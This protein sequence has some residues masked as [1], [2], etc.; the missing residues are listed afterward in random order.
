MCPHINEMQTNLSSKR[1]VLDEAL[2]AIQAKL[3]QDYKQKCKIHPD[4][5]KNR[6]PGGNETK[7]KTRK[8]V[9]RLAR[10]FVGGLVLHQMAQVRK[11]E[12]Q[13][14]SESIVT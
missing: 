6:R 5:G 13:K 2:V 1:H 14:K 9:R 10:S 12:N 11:R 7:R 3:K 4:G 8:P